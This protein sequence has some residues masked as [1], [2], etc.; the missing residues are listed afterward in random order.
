MSEAAERQLGYN[1]TS[2]LQTWRKGHYRLCCRCF[3][4]ARISGRRS[5]RQKTVCSGGTVRS[6]SANMLSF[7]LSDVG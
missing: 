3:S 7:E 1:P 5:N 6:A 4:L 2:T